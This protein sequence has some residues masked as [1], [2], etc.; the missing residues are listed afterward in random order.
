MGG[1]IGFESVYREGS[2]FWFTLPCLDKPPT[3]L[4][5]V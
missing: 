2:D 5:N 4:E 1:K 3:D